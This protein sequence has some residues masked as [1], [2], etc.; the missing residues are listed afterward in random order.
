MRF[1]GN[2]NVD[3]NDI[4][5]NLVPFPKLNL[6]SSSMTP[7]YQQ[8]DL[9]QC[10]KLIDQVFTD[11]FQPDSQLIS[12]EP[13]QSVFL[14]SAL[15]ARGSIH[16]SDLRR[17]I[18]RIRNQLKFVPWNSDGW[19]TGLCDV[20][21]MGQQYSVLNMSNNTAFWRILDRLDTRF[22]KLFKRKVFF[23]N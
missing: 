9:K 15:I 21:P 5:T 20:P 7:F 12:I 6:I 11:A 19:K 22:Q 14:A 8:T 10:S 4:V 17:N 18:D 16:I 13:K 3:I 2:L 1:E 23:H